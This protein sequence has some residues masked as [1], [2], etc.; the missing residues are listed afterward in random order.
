MKDISGFK[1][2]YDAYKNN[3]EDPDDNNKLLLTNFKYYSDTEGSEANPISIAANELINMLLI[4]IYQR[5]DLL[6]KCK[7]TKEVSLETDIQPMS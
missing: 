7:T 1:V 5:D 3:V 2:I 6:A 4:E